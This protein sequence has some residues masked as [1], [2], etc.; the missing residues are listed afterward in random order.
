MGSCIDASRPDKIRNDRYLK[1]NKLQKDCAVQLPKYLELG[2]M[3]ALY[4]HI[5]FVLD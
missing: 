4:V 2:R 3:F 5:E 1:I